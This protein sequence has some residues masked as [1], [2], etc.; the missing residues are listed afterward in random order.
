MRAKQSSLWGLNKMPS[1]FWGNLKAVVSK[2]LISKL[3]FTSRCPN[4]R[5]PAV[6]SSPV[7]QEIMAPSS[8]H[9]LPPPGTILMLTKPSMPLL[10]CSIVLQ[11]KKYTLKLQTG[12]KVT[13]ISCL[14]R[15]YNSSNSLPSPILVQV[16]K[17][18]SFNPIIPKTNLSFSSSIS[19][20][21]NS[22]GK[23]CR[24]CRCKT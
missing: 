1:G 15:A 5:W 20:T 11:T 14:P 17:S 22:F 21:N 10:I 16:S 2:E 6:Q 7:H 12:S 23:W 18:L 8:L 3:R 24:W 9:Q 13:L 4:L 19:S